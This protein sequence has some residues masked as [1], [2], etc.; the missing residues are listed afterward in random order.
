MTT[1]V[2][3]VS[4]QSSWT[5]AEAPA[6][7]GGTEKYF[8]GFIP[9]STP[10]NRLSDPAAYAYSKVAWQG[11]VAP[12][13]TSTP[14]VQRMVLDISSSESNT[15]IF[16]FFGSPES[17]PNNPSAKARMGMGAIWGVSNLGGA[18]PPA[19]EYLGDFLGRFE[20]TQ[21]AVPA[22]G[23]S[24]LPSTAHFGRRATV[25][26]DRAMFPGMRSVGEYPLSR[27]VG[28]TETLVAPSPAL[29]VDTLGYSTLIVELRAQLPLGSSGGQ[30]MTRL[31]FAYRLL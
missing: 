19:D 5:V 7:G 22:T 27:D 20:L 16:K 21:G 2:F 30:E 25:T 1:P 24:A 29:L 26:V 14:Q 18:N 12:S 8:M 9:V 15:A 10:W 17:D 11:T 4:Q 3:S 6:A 13:P 23:T 28:G 31:G